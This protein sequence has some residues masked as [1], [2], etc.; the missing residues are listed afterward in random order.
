MT[1]NEDQKRR[2]SKT[3]S[4]RPEL[5]RNFV[6]PNGTQVVLTKGRAVAGENEPLFKKPGAV[7]VVVK[8]PPNNEGDY[9][10]QFADGDQ[11]EASFD[12]LV[13]RRQ[14][15]DLQL[16][17]I[18]E[19]EPQVIFRCQTGSKAY[20]LSHEASD[21][22]Y[23]GIFIPPADVHWSLFDVPRQ[24]EFTD[25]HDEVYFE[26]E[27]FLKLALK[28]NPNILEMLWTPMVLYA[29]PLG[30]R[31]LEI[32]EA[33][34]SKHVYKTY[35]GYV[36][37]QF[38]KMRNQ[39]V[40]TGDFKPK[41]AMHLIRLQHSGIAALKTGQVMVEVNDLQPLLMSIRNGEIDFETV[42]QMAINLDASLQK[43]FEQTDLPEQPDFATVNAF[44]IE[45]RRSQV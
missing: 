33:F 44:L 45:A 40:K 15:I 31:L 14:E 26:I 25:G 42:R 41:H 8:C 18:P 34:L 16:A 23:R 9:V 32:R 19:F 43:E 24:L 17:E 6:I 4:L 1:M 2:T 36:L 5:S 3:G 10:V 13:L 11:V 28:A 29:S 37:S 21:D 22:D 30:E 12:D 39:F 7:G 20:G 38:R 35:S 27:R